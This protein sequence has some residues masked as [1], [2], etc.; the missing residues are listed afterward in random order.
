V[1]IVGETSPS[2]DGMRALPAPPPRRRLSR[3]QAAAYCGISPT[4]FDDEVRAGRYPKP[5]SKGEKGGRK[6]WDVKVL[7]AVL[8]AEAGITRASAGEDPFL[9]RLEKGGGRAGR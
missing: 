4:L 6:V 2:R 7:D 1:N 5:I 9:K 8:D 3:T